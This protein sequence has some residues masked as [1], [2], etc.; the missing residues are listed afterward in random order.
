MSVPIAVQTT[1]KIPGPFSL[2]RELQGATTGLPRP[3]STPPPP[4][5]VPSVAQ[6]RCLPPVRFHLLFRGYVHRFQARRGSRGTGDRG[7]GFI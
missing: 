4:R 3:L 1:C 6:L 7:R 2:G 5:E